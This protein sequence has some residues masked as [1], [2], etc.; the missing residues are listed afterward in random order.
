MDTRVLVVDDSPTIRR[1]VGAAL[2]S[3]DLVASSPLLPADDCRIPYR[4]TLLQ[5]VQRVD[6]VNP[7]RLCGDGRA[8]AEPLRS[9][10]S[11]R[12]DA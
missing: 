12:S 3:G 8:P 1:M 6:D 9:S 7:G 5:R 10:I 11:R 2:E 4:P